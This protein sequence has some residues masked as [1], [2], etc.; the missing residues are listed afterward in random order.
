[1]ISAITFKNNGYSLNSVTF[2]KNNT[3]ISISVSM[4]RKDIIVLDE[5]DLIELAELINNTLSEKER[6]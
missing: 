6:K 3:P 5:Y 1:M 4:N 2:E